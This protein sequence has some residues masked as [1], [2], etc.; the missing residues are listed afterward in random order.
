M[1]MYHPYTPARIQQDSILD[2]CF[3]ASK[4]LT[5]FPD[6][7]PPA[8]VSIMNRSSDRASSRSKQTAAL[9][10]VLYKQFISKAGFSCQDLSR[11]HQL[12][13]CL[14]FIWRF[15]FFSLVKLTNYSVQFSHDKNLNYHILFPLRQRGGEKN[16]GVGWQQE[17]AA[18]QLSC[19]RQQLICFPV[20][21]AQWASGDAACC[22]S[23]SSLAHLFLT[24]C[25]HRKSL[26]GFLFSIDQWS[27]TA[28]HQCL[29]P[30]KRWRETN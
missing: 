18:I 23:F 25:F 1:Q 24:W 12:K 28:A 8:C 17:I 13:W 15:F 10:V 30:L 27:G 22:F 4:V 19:R 11:L 21:G 5:V 29:G 2:W 7:T 6:G 26:S 3:C 9:S 14:G 20:Y 16:S